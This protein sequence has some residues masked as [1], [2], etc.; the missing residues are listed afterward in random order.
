MY[1]RVYQKL[2]KEKQLKKVEKL[3]EINPNHPESYKALGK[4]ALDLRE[5]GIARNNIETALQK[6]QVSSTLKLMAKLEESDKGNREKVKV[7][8]NKAEIAEQDPVWICKSCGFHMEKWNASCKSCNSF[9]TLELKAPNLRNRV[10]P[11]EKMFQ[12]NSG[13][14]LAMNS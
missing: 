6:G 13:K 12:N 1:V 11:A 8:L 3:I 5:Y 10:V 2:T 4:L 14:R 9:D 7:Y